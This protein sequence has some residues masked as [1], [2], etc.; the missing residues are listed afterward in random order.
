LELG[1]EDQTHEV[2]GT[3][4]TSNV[5]QYTRH[6]VDASLIDV[7]LSVKFENLIEINAFSRSP[8]VI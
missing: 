5:F 4:E 2:E 8:M 3:V 1:I 7:V 6:C